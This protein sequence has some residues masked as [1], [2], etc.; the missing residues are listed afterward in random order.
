MRINGSVISGD[1]RFQMASPSTLDAMSK[2]YV[3]ENT[4]RKNNWALNLYKM[5]REEVLKKGDGGFY[6]ELK[7]L[8]RTEPEILNF[9]VGQLNFVLSVFFMALKKKDGGDYTSGSIFSVA[10]ALQRHFEMNGKPIS[11]F[12]DPQ[13]LG[14]KNV[15]DNAMQ[16]KCKQGIGITKKQAAVITVSQENTLWEKKILG[17]GDPQTLLDTVF[18]VV[19]VNFGLRGG[20]E[21]RKLTR[22][23][24]RVERDAQ[25]KQYLEYMEIISKTYKGGLK[26]RKI[27]PHKARAYAISGSERCPVS[28]YTKYISKL[29]LNASPAAFYFQP[30]VKPRDDVW[31]SQVPVGHNKLASTVKNIMT[32]AGFNG[33]YTNHS[34][35][36]TTAT[37]LFQNDVSE[38]LIMNQTG[39]RSTAVHAYKRISDEQKQQVSAVLQGA[40]GSDIKSC[41]AV[42]TQV[43]E[44]RNSEAQMP[45]SAT[46]EQSMQFTFSAN[47]MHVHVYE[48]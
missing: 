30:L 24:F 7:Q 1:A 47:E 44:G 2:P 34:L 18:W 22:E 21:H 23:N 20:D 4:A 45:P 46:S 41:Y 35:R 8:L 37:R 17:D 38:Q 6:P 33:F 19:G 29:S 9:S 32:K 40:Q 48:K 10:T 42:V 43:A 5:W 27:D 39:H 25:G 3:P 16:E 12:N 28:I 14:L 11:I 31:F 13:F 15:I 26:H 36:A